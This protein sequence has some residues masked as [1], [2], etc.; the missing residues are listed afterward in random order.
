[1]QVALVARQSRNDQGF[2]ETNQAVV[3][4]G[5]LVVTG[6]RSLAAD[7]NHRRRI[8]VRTVETRNVGL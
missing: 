8:L 5:A 7:S 4:S 2:G 6:D 1:V 3:G